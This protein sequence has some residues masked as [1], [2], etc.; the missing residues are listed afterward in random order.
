MDH[1]HGAAEDDTMMSMGHSMQMTFVNSYQVELLFS[2]WKTSNAGT[3]GVACLMMIVCG[4]GAIYLK[5]LRLQLDRCMTT[6]RKFAHPIVD[7]LARGSAAF[8]SYSW[9]YLLMLCVMS[10]N[11]GICLSVVAGLS[12]GVGI[13]GRRLT[14][15]TRRGEE[16]PLTS[17]VA[18]GF[19]NCPCAQA[20]SPR[21]LIR[22]TG[23]TSEVG[24]RSTVK[25]TDL[26]PSCCA[27]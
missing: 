2:G 27:I 23:P 6:Q 21:V 8:L 7:G 26:D 16:E 3:Y 9:D 11:I 19:C 15:K 5:V 1:D 14:R 18:E 22:S 20:S 24:D 25:I 10:Y 4:V 12:L 17:E 13:F